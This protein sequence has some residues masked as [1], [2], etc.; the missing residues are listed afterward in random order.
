MLINKKAYK[1]KKKLGDKIFISKKIIYQISAINILFLILIFI[2][3]LKF[4]RF[5]NY[6]FIGA[7]EKIKNNTKGTIPFKK[8]FIP[9]DN[10]NLKIIHIIITRFML[11]FGDNFKYIKNM[12]KEYIQNG[13]SVMN[14]Y[15]IPSL[16][17]QLCKDFIWVLM[18]GEKLNI[19]FVKS[20]LNSNILFQY[21]ILNENVFKNYTEIITRESDV[22]ISTRIDYDD[23]IYYDAVNDVRKQ[24][25]INR[26]VFLYGYN[27][28]VYYFVSSG[29]YYEYYQ[30]KRNGGALALFL[31]LII[32]TKKLNKSIN[33]FDVGDHTKIGKMLL[34]NYKLYGI[35]KIDYEPFLFD[36]GSPKFI[37]NRH[38]FSH[39]YKYHLGLLKSLKE[40]EF[41]F[42]NYD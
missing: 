29:K 21:E 39:S 15:L 7:D 23:R 6:S 13:F 8:C 4:N 31:S 22:F 42:K 2:E 37:Y 18:I 1:F 17:S 10:E 20:N 34:Q 16:N 25:N 27:S 32:F 40:Q 14:K 28:G 36:E 35:E 3:I 12:N 5:D 24:I 38:K 19:T 11:E 9:L 41:H 33:I 26:P 30:N